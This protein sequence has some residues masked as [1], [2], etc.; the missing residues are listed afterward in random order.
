LIIEHDRRRHLFVQ[1]LAFEDGSIVS[2][3]VSNHYLADEHHWSRNQEEQLLG[4]GWEWHIRPYLTNW[5][6]VQATTSPD[7]GIVC[8]RALATVRELFRLVD[9]DEVFVKMF[10][11]SIRGDTPASPQYSTEEGASPLSNITVP[12]ESRRTG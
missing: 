4:L 1:F 12:E 6:D 7:I 8:R 11:S 2:E 9:D 5:I 3:T 10:P